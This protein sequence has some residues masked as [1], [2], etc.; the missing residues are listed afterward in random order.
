[1]H[2]LLFLFL[3]NLLFF[4]G[5]DSKEINLF[6]T[7]HYESDI[8][9]FKKFEE[10]TGIKVNVVSGKSKP[11]EK[12]ILDEGNSCI[13]DLLFLA[14]AGRLYSA[15]DKGIYKK[16]KSSALETKVPKQFRSKYWFGITKRARIIYYNPSETSFDEIKNLNY[17]DLS[18]KVYN[19]SIAIRQSNNVYNQSLIASFI[20][21][22][23]IEFTK[24]WLSQF[25]NNFSRNPQGN[26]R[27]QILS[28][29]AGESK[30]AIANT[31]YYALMLS[32]KKG[33]D[34]KLA[35]KKVKPFFPNQNN[36][37]THMNIS[38][39]GI[40]TNA[41]NPLNAEKFIEFLLT[42][43]AQKHIVDNTY[44]YPMI[45]GVNPSTLVAKMG[46]DFKQDNLTMV[47]SYGKWQRKAFRLMQQAG[48]N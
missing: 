10:T 46:L 1:M 16:I 11:L 20:E 37:G 35:A 7:R 23:G 4:T 41:P 14:D 28:V 39:I 45:E 12:R 48:W 47:S 32:G 40:L 30:F 44:E 31:Y 21:N 15:Q 6:T 38:G 34:Q 26:D 2:Y 8:K 19:N 18:K 33:N 24:K 5:L 3:L 43:E 42:S 9:L 29:A 13:G 25:V 36:R 17:E 27:S 22:N